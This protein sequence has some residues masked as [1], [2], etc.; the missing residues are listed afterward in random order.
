[1]QVADLE[2][3]RQNN[4][5]INLQ[6]PHSGPLIDPRTTRTGEINYPLLSVLFCN[7]DGGG[8]GGEDWIDLAQDRTGGWFLWM[9]WWTFGFNKMR[10]NF[11]TSWGPALLHGDNYAHYLYFISN[12][13]LIA[14]FWSWTN[15]LVN[16]TC[17]Y[18]LTILI[19]FLI[20]PFTSL[21]V[22]NSRNVCTVSYVQR[23]FNKALWPAS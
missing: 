7:W 19:V 14:T 16:L 5:N 12:F 8:R 1:M 23:M 2:V 21:F 15:F 10:V 6:Y 11:L 13:I 20:G 22:S 18:P 9:R 3:L 17:S 4:D